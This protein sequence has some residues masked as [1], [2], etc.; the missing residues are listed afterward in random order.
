[1]HVNK[2]AR[3]CVATPQRSAC[4]DMA[5]AW[6]RNSLHSET[7]ASCDTAANA[8]RTGGRSQSLFEI[9]PPVLDADQPPLQCP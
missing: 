5:S 2:N 7:E 4:M 6:T 3:S 1:M 8:V 9:A